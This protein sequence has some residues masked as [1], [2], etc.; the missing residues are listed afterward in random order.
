MTRA[1]LDFDFVPF[2]EGLI[3]KE[4]P[5]RGGGSRPS[6]APYNR[7]AVYTAPKLAP[8]LKSDC[9]LESSKGSYCLGVKDMGCGMKGAAAVG[10]NLVVLHDNIAVAN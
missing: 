1:P 3:L 7:C 5:L 10:N 4:S 6:E 8:V 2:C 9:C